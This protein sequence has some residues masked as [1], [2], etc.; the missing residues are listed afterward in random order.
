MKHSDNHPQMSSLATQ[1]L[2]AMPAMGDERFARTVIYLHTHNKDG[3][4]GFVLNK[5][6]TMTHRDLIKATAPKQISSVTHDGSNLLEKPVGFGGPVEE[7]RGFVLRLDR[8]QKN[9]G[10][11]SS[12]KVSSSLDDLKALCDAPLDQDAFV[13]MGYAGWGSGQLEAELAGN[14]WLTGPVDASLIFETKAD[15]LYSVAMSALGVDSA[16]LSSDVGHA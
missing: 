15:A 9:E 13:V 7:T 14:A 8:A 1:F 12:L 6:L 16:R 10:N 2:I 4:V 3:A 11:S 5:Q